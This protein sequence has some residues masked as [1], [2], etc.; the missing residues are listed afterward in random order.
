MNR[1]IRFLHT[2]DLH[3]GRPFS[4]IGSLDTTW[5]SRITN[6]SPSAFNILCDYAIE[7][8]VDFV[9]VA[10]DV[11]DRSPADYSDYALFFAGLKRLAQELSL[12]H[13]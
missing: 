12:I 8:K 1:S 9:L 2:A 7:K 10:G 6:A 11:F 4:G 3:I 5:Q 13:I